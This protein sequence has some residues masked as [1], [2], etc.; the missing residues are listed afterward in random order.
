MSKIFLTAAFI[1]VSILSASAAQPRHHQKPVVLQAADTAGIV[2]IRTD[3]NA[4][5]FNSNWDYS[6]NKPKDQNGGGN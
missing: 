3:S 1:C 5:A 4:A 2:I 6:L